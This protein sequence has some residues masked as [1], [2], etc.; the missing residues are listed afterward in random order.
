MTK[1]RRCSPD[2]SSLC[3]LLLTCC[4][5]PPLNRESLLFWCFSIFFFF[6]FCFKY[7][8]LPPQCSIS[9]ADV[10]LQCSPYS[11]ESLNVDF[12]VP[13]PMRPKQFAEPGGPVT[14][15][16]SFTVL[17]FWTSSIAVLFTS[18][19]HSDSWLF[20]PFRRGV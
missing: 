8:P 14:L 6:L 19:E 1:T 16:R 20:K 12:C 15:V 10:L 13:F 18:K 4:P 3:F 5:A 9:S 7:G 17:F 11:S 2:F